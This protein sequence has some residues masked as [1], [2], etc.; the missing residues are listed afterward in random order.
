MILL[1]NADGSPQFKPC[2][3]ADLP[4]PAIAL[5]R[6]STNEI[7]E[8]VVNEWKDY[9]YMKEGSKHLIFQ[10]GYDY[11]KKQGFIRTFSIN[12]QL[13]NEQYS[14]EYDGMVAREEL[15][16][17][18]EIFKKTTEL[19]SIF[20]SANEPITLQGGFNYTDPNINDACYM[21]NRCVHVFA[22]TSENSILAHAIVRLN[23]KSIPYPFFDLEIHNQNR[24]ELK[25]NKK[26]AK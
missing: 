9:V 21:G 17:A 11:S 3:E 20:N 15:L 5:T 16:V 25:N 1:N 19:Q 2:F 13:I 18:F 23:D 22:S 7:I 24:Q 26:E 6:D 10:Q 8:V 4:N 14:A 12:K